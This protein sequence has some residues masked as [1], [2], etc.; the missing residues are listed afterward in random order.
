M[1]REEEEKEKKKQQIV[2]AISVVP[3]K[4]WSRESNLR[5]PRAGD[6]KKT[7]KKDLGG[8]K[9]HLRIK[10]KNE[11]NKG[12]IPSRQLTQFSSTGDSNAF[13]F[14]PEAE[15]DTRFRGRS[16]ARDSSAACGKMAVGLVYH[17]MRA[18]T[19]QQ[20]RIKRLLN[21]CWLF[22][23]FGNAK[24]KSL[25]STTPLAQ[26]RKPKAVSPAEPRHGKGCSRAN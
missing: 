14:W 20:L 9:S 16:T 11:E 24:K 13:F 3:Q 12:K 26:S 10:K 8:I 18:P 21:C 25:I 2:V 22:F 5:R 19:L 7:S 15:K 6:K 23:I 4:N 17:P 1:K